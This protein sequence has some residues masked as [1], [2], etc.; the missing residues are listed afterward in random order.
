MSRNQVPKRESLQAIEYR[1]YYGTDKATLQNIVK[2]FRA[3]QALPPSN[4][5]SYYCIA[6]YHGEP[7]RGIG[8]PQPWWGGYCHH[9][10]VLFPL[11]H[12]AYL[13]RLENALRKVPGCDSVRIPFWDELINYG[14]PNAPIPAILTSPQFEGERNPLYS[15]SLQG[16]F[17]KDERYAKPVGYETVRYPLS[18]LVGTAEDK[19]ESAIHNARFVSQEERVHILN[20]NVANWLSGHV[21]IPDDGAGT[22]RPKDVTAVHER[23]LKCLQA[24]NYTVFSNTTSQ[25]DY[26]K[27]RT[28]RDTIAVAL[29]SPHNSIHLAV[30]GFY[31]KGEYSASPIIG[32]NGDM[33][34]NEV[35]GF[36]PIFYLHHCFIDYAFWTW[37]KNH[38]STTVGSIKFD[39]Q[40]KGTQTDTSLPVPDGEPQMPVGTQLTLDTP[41][42]PFQKDDGTTYFTSNDLVD[43]KGQLGYDYGRGSLDGINEGV[44]RGIPP[45]KVPLI[46]KISGIDRR[47]YAG[48]F[49][50]RLYGYN[51][52][53]DRVEVGREAVLSRLKLSECANCQNSLVEEYFIPMHEDLL[54]YLAKDEGD[55]TKYRTIVGIQTYDHEEFPRER[56][57]IPVV[58]PL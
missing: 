43:I 39:S 11:W 32:A 21:D 36:D 51:T 16:A 14:T 3:V 17:G 45:G 9:G 13:L 10:D 30:G 56:S 20:A 29:E 55:D 5:D 50:V 49:V 23:F 1:Y 57:K 19:K 48:S 25:N 53:G 34:A 12:R 8:E 47:D 40:W 41:L 35:A 33:G 46:Q 15:Y 24:P 22:P 44:L 7:F 37:Q 38:D 52:N 27:R 42:Y 4:P 54:P 31:Q 58:M 18:G 28:S 6:G 2:A 26:N